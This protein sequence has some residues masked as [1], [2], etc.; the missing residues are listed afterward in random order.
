MTEMRNCGQTF[1]MCIQILDHVNKY[2]QWIFSPF[3]FCNLRK[4]YIAFTVNIHNASQEMEKPGEIRAT[5]YKTLWIRIKKVTWRSAEPQWST[6]KCD[7]R[8]PRVGVMQQ[9]H[10]AHHRRDRRVHCRNARILRHHFPCPLPLRF[11][12]LRQQNQ[13]QYRHQHHHPAPW[14]PEA[15]L[16]QL[17]FDHKAL[18]ST[19]LLIRLRAGSS[20]YIDIDALTAAGAAPT[21]NQPEVVQWLWSRQYH[22]RYSKWIQSNDVY[23]VMVALNLMAMHEFHCG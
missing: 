2:S 9:H 1:T 6:W 12:F 18:L 7:I 23:L 16:L 20:F 22:G 8:R 15:Q 17:H 3:L 10:T 4:E 13:H 5:V 21:I 14:S 11:H 19:T